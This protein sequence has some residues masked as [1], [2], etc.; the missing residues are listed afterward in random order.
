MY[1]LQLCHYTCNTKGLSN[2]LSCNR[3]YGLWRFLPCYWN[4]Y[5]LCALTCFFDRGC[6][7]S[8]KISQ[9]VWLLEVCSCEILLESCTPLKSIVINGATLH[10]RYSHTSG[11]S[12]SSPDTFIICCI[13]IYKKLLHTFIF[14]TFWTLIIST[15]KI[16]KFQ[17]KSLS[18]QAFLDISPVLMYYLKWGYVNLLMQYIVMSKSMITLESNIAQYL[19]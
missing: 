10:L 2:I 6:L 16:P 1:E 5:N 17:S 8:A 18:S 4:L 19:D 15:L 9:T 11:I 7:T 12:S 3:S 14:F 13:G